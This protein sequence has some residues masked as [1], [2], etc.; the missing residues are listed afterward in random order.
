MNW[1]R[2]EDRQ[3]RSS[4]SGSLW[5]WVGDESLRSVL[6]INYEPEG[7]L[8]TL[9]WFWQLHYYVRFKPW[10]LTYKERVRPTSAQAPS[11]AI[12]FAVIARGRA[13]QTLVEV[14]LEQVKLWCRITYLHVCVCMLGTHSQLSCHVIYSLN[15]IIDIIMRKINHIK[16]LILSYEMTVNLSFWQ[17]IYNFNYKY[18]FNL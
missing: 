13:G 2:G 5:G 15:Y 16:Y 17:E 18:N 4:R 14:E 12:I 6:S 10:A 8:L 9:T 1:W 3:R 11:D 7:A